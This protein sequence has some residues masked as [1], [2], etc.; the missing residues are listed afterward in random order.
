MADADPAR[1]QLWQWIHPVTG[2][3]C[4]GHAVH[5]DPVPDVLHAEPVGTAYVPGRGSAVRVRVDELPAW[6]TSRDRADF[7]TTQT[8]RIL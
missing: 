2:R 7:P 5:V 4:E 8:N 6:P 1:T 3:P